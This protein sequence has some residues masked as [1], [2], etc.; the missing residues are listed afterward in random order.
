[1][2][3][4]DA[5]YLRQVVYEAAENQAG[6]LMPLDAKDKHGRP[7]HPWAIVYERLTACEDGLAYHAACEQ[8][9][10]DLYAEIGRLEAEVSRLTR[11]IHNG[12]A[13]YEW[14]TRPEAK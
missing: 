3:D 1:V 13:D 11:M 5:A 14:P 12:P 10:H 6:W 2:K 9:V 7:L 4:A 8:R